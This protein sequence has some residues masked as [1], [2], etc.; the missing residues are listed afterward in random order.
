MKKEEALEY[1][2]TE[3]K[4]YGSISWDGILDICDENLRLVRYCSKQLELLIEKG[5]L[6]GE[7]DY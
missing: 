1:C 6:E 5:E 3:I 4:E 7:L 2:I